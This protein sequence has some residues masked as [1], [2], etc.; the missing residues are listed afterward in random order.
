MCAVLHT[1]ARAR[2]CTSHARKDKVLK[3]K[4]GRERMLALNTKSF[5]RLEEK[6]ANGVF[7]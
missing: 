7:P 4:R 2:V 5:E 6:K 1:H 3:L